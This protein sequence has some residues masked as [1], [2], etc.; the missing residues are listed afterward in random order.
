MFVLSKNVWFCVPTDCNNLSFRSGSIYQV[1]TCFA[2]GPPRW[3]NTCLESAFKGIQLRA[4]AGM[5]FFVDFEQRFANRLWL[6]CHF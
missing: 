4:D 1:L 2:E 3:A 6:S 5:A